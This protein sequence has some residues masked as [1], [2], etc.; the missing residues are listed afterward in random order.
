MTV[1][2]EDEGEASAWGL[3]ESAEVRREQREDNGEIERCVVD[4]VFVGIGVGTLGD[5]I[6][7]EGRC[8]LA[9]V[10]LIPA[11]ATLTCIVGERILCTRN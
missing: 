3:K 11:A 1:L 6:S 7:E 9:T 5:A 2:V 10:A 8:G 4:V